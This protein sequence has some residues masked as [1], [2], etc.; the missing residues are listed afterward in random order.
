MDLRLK[1]LR[2]EI[3]VIMCLDVLKFIELGNSIQAG[4]MR[5]A[6]KQSL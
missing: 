4:F 6:T 1:V 2:G 3:L 5:R